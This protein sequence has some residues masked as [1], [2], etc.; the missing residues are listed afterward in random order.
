MENNNLDPISKRQNELLKELGRGSRGFFYGDIKTEP[1]FRRLSRENSNSEGEGFELL[2]VGDLKV[3][4]EKVKFNSADKISNGAYGTVYKLFDGKNRDTRY[5]A[6]KM[7]KFPLSDKFMTHLPMMF[8]REVV[9]FEY[10]SKLGITPKII[11]ANY[12]KRYIV[13]ERLD[14]TL[15]DMVKE[16]E[17]GPQHIQKLIELISKIIFTPYRHD[18][19]HNNNIMWSEKESSFYFIDWG[20]Y[21]LLPHS[22]P[23]ADYPFLVKRFPGVDPE[24]KIYH[25]RENPK[26]LRLMGDTFEYVDTI[27]KYHRSKGREEWTEPSMDWANFLVQINFLSD[28]QDYLFDRLEGYE[29]KCSKRGPGGMGYKLFLKKKDKKSKGVGGM[30]YKL[31]LKKSRKKRK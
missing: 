6:K 16:C 17:F 3:D 12:E 18:D 20:Y 24:T 31:L 2:E 23:L 13:M 27:L 22:S 30:G 26:N 15:G 28:Y 25:K 7:L 9:A 10:L 8:H 4:L 19:F 21:K 11:Y 5:V 1:E 29:K 14:K